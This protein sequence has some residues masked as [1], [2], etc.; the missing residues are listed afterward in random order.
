MGAS[1]FEDYATATTAKE[2][3]RK[4]VEEA[5]YFNGHGGYSG[6]IA[7]KGDFV[8]IEVPSKWKGKEAAYADHLM[9]VNDRRVTDKWGPAGCIL[10]SSEELYESVPYATTT[11]KNKQEGARKWETYFEIKDSAGD[12]AGT[13]ASQTEAEAAA[14]EL[15]K[16]NSQSYTILI[17]KRLA[18]GTPVIATIRPKYKSVKSAKTMNQ[19]LFFGWASS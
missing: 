2:A 11:E 7:E 6:T 8:M 12:I 13:R 17:K 14:K 19:Y 16:R 18:Y 5:Q 9:D 10:I 15:A 3:F 1:T 4:A